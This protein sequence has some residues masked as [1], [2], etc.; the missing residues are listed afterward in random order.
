MSCELS[1]GCLLIATQ[2]D[3]GVFDILPAEFKNASFS[4]CLS[5]N[6]KSY[7]AV[8]TCKTVSNKCAG[9]CRATTMI[10][11]LNVCRWVTDDL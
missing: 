3:K 2:S 4:R 6:S 5:L 1:Q 7:I 8:S 10:I 11:A 9:T